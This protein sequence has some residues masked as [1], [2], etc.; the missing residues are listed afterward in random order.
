MLSRSVMRGEG[1]RRYLTDA[2]SLASESESDWQ[3]QTEAIDGA[4][5]TL[6]K[7]WIESNT[8]HSRRGTV[9]RASKY[10]SDISILT[11]SIGSD[12]HSKV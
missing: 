9:C 5:E 12:Q 6:D 2:C 3:K 11:V 8:F 4:D 1:T 7:P 10:R